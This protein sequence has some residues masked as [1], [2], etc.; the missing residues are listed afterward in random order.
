MAIVHKISSIV[1][2]RVSCDAVAANFNIAVLLAKVVSKIVPLIPIPTSHVCE[3]SN[4]K[5]QAQ[6]HMPAF[7]W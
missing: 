2:S 1:L 4:N 7:F 5:T 3:N 6:A